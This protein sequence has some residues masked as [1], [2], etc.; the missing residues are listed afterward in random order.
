[1]QIIEHLGQFDSW[2][3]M[4]DILLQQIDA[5]NY[6]KFID[7]PEISPQLKQS[8]S[9]LRTA[10][11]IPGFILPEDEESNIALLLESIFSSRIDTR[12]IEEILNG[13]Q[14]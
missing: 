9:R 1:M 4:R 12:T 3:L 10:Q 11:P 8:L 14:P 2:G 13:H 7:L 5:C 6:T